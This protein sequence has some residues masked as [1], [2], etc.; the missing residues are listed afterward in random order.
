MLT[1]SNIKYAINADW[2]KP[3]FWQNNQQIIGQSKGRNTTYFCQYESLKMVLRHYYR[4]GLIGKF[5]KDNYHFSSLESTRPYRELQLLELMASQNLPA[6]K[7]IAGLVH[8]KGTFYRADLLI[9][10]IP[11]AQDAYHRLLKGALSETIWE[12]IG[13]TIAKFHALGIYHADLN[14]HNILIDEHNKTWLIDFDRGEQR[15][16]NSSWQQANLERLLRSLNKEKK[17]NSEFFWQ[18]SDWE[19]LQKGYNQAP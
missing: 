17:K 14:I 15:A 4:G 11:N 19:L 6:P 16:P 2:F 13:A 3:E 18:P 5:N 7:P 9:E 10:M 8:K 1:E 12:N